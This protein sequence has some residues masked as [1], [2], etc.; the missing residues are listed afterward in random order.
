MSTEPAH[1]FVPKKMSLSVWGMDASGRAFIESYQTVQIAERAVEFES[2]RPLRVGEIMGAGVNGLKSRFRVL[3]SRLYV[4]DTYRI[5][6]ED[7]GTACMWTKELAS[8]DELVDTKKERR[9]HTRFPARGAVYVHNKDRT[10]S[11][12]ARLVDISIGGC[13]I[14][15]LAP[16][17]KGTQL[18]LTIQSK[19]LSI[20]LRASVC[21]SH[22][23]IG[24]GVELNGF[25]SS[26]DEAR[27][28]QLLAT[29]EKDVSG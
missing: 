22:P 11:S 17:A 18:D 4:K 1:R 6:L 9:R 25:H 27:Y 20:E 16:V 19:G 13:Y 29:I 14:E 12:Q 2:P 28:S 10:T 15:T 8:P 24:M 7:L 26:E 21:T 23:S 5:V 3:S